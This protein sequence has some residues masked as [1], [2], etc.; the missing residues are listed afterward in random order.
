MKSTKSR[1]SQRRSALALALGALLA[2]ADAGARAQTTADIQAQAAR[3]KAAYLQTLQQ[4]CEIES[5]SRDLEG[6]QRMAETAAQRLRALG[7]DV[8]LLDAN[9]GIY[10]MEDTPERV[11]PVVQAVFTGKGTRRILL[12]G[13]MD[14][15]YPKGWIAKQPFRIDGDRVY[16]LGVADDK[17][18]IA[19]ILHAVAMLKEA[20]VDD[21]GRLTVMFNS[22]EEIS[23]PGARRLITAAGAEHDVT[24][25]FEPSAVGQDKLALATAGIGSVTLE[26]TGR[27]SHA[28]ANP[29]AGVNALVELSNQI[30]QTRDL[31]DPATGLKL[32]WTLSKAGTVRNMIPPQASAQAD[33]RVLRV[34]DYDRVEKDLQTRS[35]RKLLPDAKVVMRLERRRPPLEAP[36]ASVALASHAQAIYKEMGLALGFDAKASGG[37]TDAAFAALQTKAAVVESFGL[38]GFGY[39]SDKDEY[40]L[41]SAIEPRLTLAVRLIADVARGKVPGL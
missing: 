2:L 9:E 1:S 17:Q 23:S 5:G 3:H 16:G 22:D 32:N 29:E 19:L 28:G 39:H 33:V 24:M 40:V 11:G 18:G 10:R 12:I 34:A 31:S 25:S 35:A 27:A 41:A 13:H 26:V 30:L 7:G 21:Y 38:P 6:L 37:G 20:G 4:L 36:P 8:K 15:V 14:T